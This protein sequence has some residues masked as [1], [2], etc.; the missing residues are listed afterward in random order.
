M[1]RRKILKGLF[2]ALVA[3][4]LPSQLPTPNTQ[5][6]K[7]PK[8]GVLGAQA[9]KKVALPLHETVYCKAVQTSPWLNGRAGIL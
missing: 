6:P 3:P 4:F 5:Y 8:S 1:G 2:G 7:L 9:M